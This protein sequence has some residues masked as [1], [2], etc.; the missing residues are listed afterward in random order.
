MNFRNSK[1]LPFVFFSGNMQPH[2]NAL[3]LGNANAPS[4]E[5]LEEEELLEDLILQYMIMSEKR[6]KYRGWPDPPAR[7]TFIKFPCLKSLRP[8]AMILGKPPHRL[9]WMST[10]LMLFSCS[11]NCSLIC[12][13]TCSIETKVYYDAWIDY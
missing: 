4:N 10:I 8:G 11:R 6:T 5:W 12:Q 2:S 13:A 3:L 9:F 1:N 7:G